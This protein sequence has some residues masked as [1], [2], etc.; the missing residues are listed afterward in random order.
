M[1][2][3]FNDSLL[4]EL[5]AGLRDLESRSQRRTL[6]EINGLNLC[7]NDYL[8]LAD[9]PA[10]KQ[11]VI[12]AVANA[13]RIGGT[14]SRL[15][16][17]HAAVWNELEEEFAAFAGS[18]AALY[19]GSGYAANI[20]LLTSLASKNDV[21]FSDAL[22]H[23]SI[24]D[25]IRL[26]GARK[27]IYSHRD[28]NVLESSLKENQSK[29][30]RKLI[31]TE[32]VFSMEGDVVP[33]DAIVALAEKYGVGVIV[34][35]AHATAVHGPDGRG[36]ATQFMADGRILAAMHTCGKALAS[37]GAFVCGTAVLREHLINH[38]RIFIFGTALPPYMAEQIRSALRLAAGMNTERAELLSRSQDFAKSLQRDGW[39]TLGTTTQIVP[40]VIGANDAAV[41]AAEFLQRAGFA[42]R[43]I[44]PPTVPPGTARI[45][46]SVT[47]K[48]TAAELEKLATA[49]S[50][51]RA[52]S[53]HPIP[54]ALAGRA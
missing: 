37:A 39:E 30:G 18:E 13:T 14:G 23:A 25:G 10:L 52:R 3:E 50:T 6:A 45:R 53:H 33:L 43:A 9:N 34:D 32:T 8:G 29:P 12:D 15:L 27:I 40:A 35:E 48:L 22:N 42:V 11:S 24:I 7:S 31:V 19:F 47:H 26:S 2:S 21:F 44:R 5:Q 38:A 36:I 49:L 4:A 16:S 54:L 41:A 20:G 1:P 46:F 51:W 28:L 17:G